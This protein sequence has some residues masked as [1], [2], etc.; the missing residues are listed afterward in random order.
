MYFFSA[1]ELQDL[2]VLC[3]QLLAISAG[4]YFLI[5]VFFGLQ[6]R[7]RLIPGIALGTI[8]FIL[9][10]NILA[11]LFPLRTAFP[12]ASAILL[13][14]GSIA[15]WTQ[16][17][18]IEWRIPAADTA[19]QLS[20]FGG[21]LILFILINRGLAILDD[22]HNLP[23]VSIMSTGKIP[24]PF[25]LRTDT[26]IAYHYGLHLFSTFLVSQGNFFP[27]SAYDVSKALMLSLTLSTAWIWFRNA[28]LNTASQLSCLLIFALAG[29]TR[30]LLLLTP[31]SWLQ[32][33]S[34][35]LSLLG[36]GHSTGI[37]LTENL[38]SAWNIEGAGPFPF[39]FAFANGVFHP[40]IF[41]LGSSSTLPILT[42][43]IILL[44]RPKH[45]SLPSMVLCGL[46]ISSL[47]LSAELWLAIIYIGTALVVLI[48]LLQKKPVK[49]WGHWIV[50]LTIALPVIMVQGG[51]VTELLMDRFNLSGN[52]AVTGFGSFIFQ[53][54]PSLV[55]AHLGAL[56]LTNI[57]TLILALFEIGPILLLLPFTFFYLRK[58]RE[59]MNLLPAI[60]LL[61]CF[62]LSI[63]SLFIHYS[64]QRDTARIVGNS[65]YLWL[66][67]GLSVL[68]KTETTKRLFNQTT[69]VACTLSTLGGLVFLSIM[70]ISIKSPLQSYFITGPDA[71]FTVNY[72]NKL[73][74]DAWIF[75]PL[76]YRAAT[77]FGRITDAKITP[78]IFMDSYKELMRNPIP[79]VVSSA[80]YDYYYLDENAWKALTREQQRTFQDSC[81]L[82]VEAIE[83]TIGNLRIL[84]DIRKCR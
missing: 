14:A 84:Y 65:C 8:L 83:D 50:I 72:W 70:L 22:Y 48:S 80:G 81:V 53:P 57:N 82:S 46:C 36:S 6:P 18:L 58:T 19:I 49:H 55:S 5:A 2:L 23:L 56:A 21:L 60:L 54:V 34:T 10:A 28:Q 43:L 71:Q 62:T 17:K 29:G 75:D 11:Q 9:L 64:V 37:W 47:G 39:P 32:N 16:R 66:L 3:I 7:D 30:W 45:W 67:L 52:A 73:E 63:L 33:A 42:I 79:S 61:G 12:V 15:I 35:S 78:Y 38:S 41:S 27:W 77:I 76:P 74:E 1:F 24:P 59:G 51:V 20:V 13:L 69:R 44:L 68:F 40:L 26:R 31:A 4:G 25:Y